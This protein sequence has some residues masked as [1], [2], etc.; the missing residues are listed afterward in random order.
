MSAGKYVS[1]GDED[2]NTFGRSD[3]KISFFGST[4]VV[5][6][7]C[8]AVGTTTISQVATS[9]KWAFATSTAAKALVKQ[10]QNIQTALD[11]LGLVAS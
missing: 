11:N 8:T 3:G 10:V 1:P 4:P 6:Q 7:T 5:Q 9:G 2:G